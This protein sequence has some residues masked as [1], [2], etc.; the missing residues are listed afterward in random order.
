MEAASGGKHSI[1]IALTA[2]AYANVVRECLDLG[3][4]DHL[5]KP[6]SLATLDNTLNQWLPGPETD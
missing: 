3:M 2:H 5:A 1:I 6:V 4:D